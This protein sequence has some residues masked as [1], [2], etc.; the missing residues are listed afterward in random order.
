MT[1]KSTGT[2]LAT[3]AHGAWHKALW[4]DHFTAVYA[5]KAR[6]AAVFAACTARL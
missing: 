6:V 3:I 1:G 2:F 4:A 5:F